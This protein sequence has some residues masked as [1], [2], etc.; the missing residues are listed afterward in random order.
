[1]VDVGD[2]P[3]PLPSELPSGRYVRLVVRDTGCGI[4]EEA[5]PRI[6]D[7]FFTTKAEGKGTGLGLMIVSDAVRKSHGH[8]QVHSVVGEGTTF[9]VHWPAM[10]DQAVAAGAEWT[11]RD[12]PGGKETVLLVEDDEL[13]RKLLAGDLA[14]HGYSVLEAASGSEALTLVE[15]SSVTFHAVVTDLVMPE[16]TGHDL[17]VFVHRLRPGTKVLYMS[18]RTDDVVFRQLQANQPHLLLEKPFRLEELA[19]RVRGLLDG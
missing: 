4:P 6:F 15:D 3:Q 8:L 9:E 13:L 18:G 2:L 17:V 16:M 19:R 7:P 14:R 5:L 11:A 10:S 12:V 1:M